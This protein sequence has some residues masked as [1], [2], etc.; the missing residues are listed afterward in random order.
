MITI[1]KS[2]ASQCGATRLSKRKL[3]C[4]GFGATSERAIQSRFA[5]IGGVPV[6]DAA[7]RGLIERRDQPAHL[8]FIC[9]GVGSLLKS[10]ELRQDAAVA[11]RPLR[12]LSG[13]FRG[14]FCIG[15]E[16][17]YLTSI[18]SFEKIEAQI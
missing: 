7:L 18:L 3:F 6:N 1:R 8:V 14:G 13:A 11:Q 4:R 9:S 17:N 10:A 12:V 15:H 5:T 16:K 2:S